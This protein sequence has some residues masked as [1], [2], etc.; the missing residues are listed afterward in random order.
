MDLQIYKCKTALFLIYLLA[1]KEL[2]Y[3]TE[4]ET[5]RDLDQSLGNDV[6]FSLSKFLSSS[7]T[8]LTKQ[9]LL[10]IF[11][12]N[13]KKKGNLTSKNE[14]KYIQ[15]HYKAISGMHEQINQSLL[16]A[17]KNYVNDR[18]LIEIY[19]QLL[20]EDRVDLFPLYLSVMHFK[21]NANQIDSL[22]L[23]NI[24]VILKF[25]GNKMLLSSL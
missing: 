19:L 21:D 12:F 6:Y 13:E 18:S 20:R 25:Y 10:Y 11:P 16:K 1:F 22:F 17:N 7:G 5:L 3:N 14:I 23:Q 15:D 8:P 24:N 2:G 9:Q 4:D